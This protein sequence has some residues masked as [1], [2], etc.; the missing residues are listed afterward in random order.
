MLLTLS[1]YILRQFFLRFVL[2]LLALTALLVVFDILANAD[3]VLEHQNRVL[4]PLFS[5]AGLRLPQIL[6]LLVPMA[7]LF[8]AA[9][10]FAQLV[11]RQEMIALRGFGLPI[12][13]IAGCLLFGGLVICGLH[14]VFANTVA[15][16]AASYLQSWAQQDYRGSPDEIL[17]R[18]DAKG[19]F[20]SHNHFVSAKHVSTDGHILYNMSI[21]ERGEDGLIE[22]V[23][24]ARKAR[25]NGE[26]WVLSGVQPPG[27]SV[28]LAL[29]PSVF[30]AMHETE[31]EM[32]YAQ[33]ADIVEAGTEN[34]GYGYRYEAWFHYK[35]AHPLSSL[36]MILIA[37]PMAL[38]LARRGN[39]LGVGFAI[40]LAG[41]CYF[42]FES[43][44]L[45]LGE[46]GILPPLL[47]VWSP[48]MLT[49]LISVWILLLLEG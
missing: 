32:S 42:I 6:S 3:V 29:M 19:W 26:T 1:Q 39:I 9:V 37:A 46:T 40:V 24:T 45:S 11:A 43:L 23:I 7:S 15:P 49:L 47:A 20:A 31:A 21:I 14:F 5:Y 33:L 36:L 16:K 2:I 17:L 4:A 48:P 41:F 34:N 38:Q 12:Y 25:Y 8:S 44:F 35:I 30:T 22:R 27:A 13:R 18:A 28:E 10:V